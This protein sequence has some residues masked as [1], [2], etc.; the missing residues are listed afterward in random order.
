MIIISIIIII[1]IERETQY[2]ELNR[3]EDREGRL[4]I[5]LIIVRFVYMY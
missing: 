4:G 3:E 2:F 1:N 5:Y